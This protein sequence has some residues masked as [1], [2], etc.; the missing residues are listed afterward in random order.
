MSLRDA[1]D[2]DGR[3]SC[4]LAKGELVQFHG[5]H[6]VILLCPRCLAFLTRALAREDVDCDSR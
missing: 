3:C 5:H 1:L 6:V 2:G 4:C